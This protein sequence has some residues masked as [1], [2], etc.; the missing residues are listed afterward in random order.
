MWFEM[1]YPATWAGLNSFL[2]GVLSLISATFD[3]MLGQPV[4]VL[5]LA[6]LLMAVVLL[7][8]RELFRASKK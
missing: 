6:A 8:V 3:A 5:F 7:V 1:D 4:L 2:S